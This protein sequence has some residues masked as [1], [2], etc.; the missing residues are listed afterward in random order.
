MI[1]LGEKKT[2]HNIL[3]TVAYIILLS[4]LHIYAYVV[5]Q[6]VLDSDKMNMAF[7]LYPSSFAELINLPIL[8]AVF[9]MS[10]NV[11][12]VLLFYD[13]VTPVTVSAFL[14]LHKYLLCVFYF[15]GAFLVLSW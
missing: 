1:T 2:V 5:L 10:S 4:H 9:C 8:F 13:F 14:P 11:L 3:Y 7:Q 12:L 15:L 6:N